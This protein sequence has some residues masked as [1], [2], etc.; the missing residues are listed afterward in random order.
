MSRIDDI[1]SYMIQTGL[2]W[3]SLAEGT[4]VLTP[5][6]DLPASI[7]V[8]VEDPV[9]VF[10]APIVDLPSVQGDRAELFKLLL[11]LNSELLHSSYSL[12][13][14]RIVL[15]GAQQLENLDFNEFQAMVDDMAIGLDNHH[16]RI[17]PWFHANA[18]PA[19]RGEG[20]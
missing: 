13:D 6:T 17:A 5:D 19:T 4:Y 9:V 1:E 18:T 11:E 12:Q 7:A 8:K 10:S 16:G 14:E 20:N 2:P 15:A 3:Q